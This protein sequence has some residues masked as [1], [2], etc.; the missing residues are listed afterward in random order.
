MVLPFMIAAGALLTVQ[1]WPTG[2]SARGLEFWLYS[3]IAAPGLWL[4]AFAFRQWW[5]FA[6]RNNKADYDR[7]V[8]LRQ[9]VWWAARSK[10]VCLQALALIGPFGDTPYKLRALA[11]GTATPARETTQTIDGKHPGD[12]KQTVKVV[13]WQQALM[14]TEATRQK[15]LARA[16]ARQLVQTLQEQ[17]IDTRSAV[18]SQ[19]YW[20][21]DTVAW[22][23]FRDGLAAAPLILPE[24]TLPWS[25]MATLDQAFDQLHAQVPSVRRILCAGVS[26]PAAVTDSPLPA[27]EVAF[28]WLLGSDGG[29]V[30][31]HRSE[32]VNADQGE[33]VADACAQVM[34]YADLAKP[35]AQ[36]VVLDEDA[37]EPLQ[38]AQWAAMNFV[39]APFFGDPGAL[40]APAMLT[41]AALVARQQQSACGWMAADTSGIPVIGVIVPNESPAQT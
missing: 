12:P 11:M 27:G 5:F 37:V 14:E 32:A 38:A 1:L 6:A 31:M 10:P 26:S 23:T 7:M 24:T 22:A 34:A 4:V 35:P 20:S 16:L 28:A 25:G 8:A 40:A 2:K 9:Q 41:V 21:G 33:A 30:R 13:R 3:T 39:Q 15:R 18:I 19:V 29:V 17:G 36:A